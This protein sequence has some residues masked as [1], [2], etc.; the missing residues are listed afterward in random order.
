MNVQKNIKRIRVSKG[1]T[2]KAVALYLGVIPQTYYR[3][4]NEN[5]NVNSIYLQKISEY[6]QVDIKVFFDDKL[7][8]NVINKFNKS[9]VM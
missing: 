5:K 6:F 4:E 2:Q 7:T 1:I 8:E 3:I 9:E